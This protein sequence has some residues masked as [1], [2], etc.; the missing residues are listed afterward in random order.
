MFTL[1]YLYEIVW[2]RDTC[3]P[4]GGDYED[5]CRLGCDVWTLLYVYC[6][7]DPSACGADDLQFRQR[8]TGSSRSSVQPALEQY[9]KFMY[10]LV[11]ISTVKFRVC[12][13]VRA[14]FA[15]A[16]LPTLANLHLISVIYQAA[17]DNLVIRQSFD[18]KLMRII[19]VYLLLLHG[20]VDASCN[21]RM[22]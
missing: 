10:T 15:P 7:A 21:T 19:P 22:K 9:S 1:P 5:C 11:L 14:T 3:C 2:S 8:H 13:D 18:V 6:C 12:S 20:S 4:H 17:I 16:S